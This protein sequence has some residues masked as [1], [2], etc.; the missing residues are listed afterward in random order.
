MGKS[1]NMIEVE[2]KTIF[3]LIW[4]NLFLLPLSCIFLH[5]AVSAQEKTCWNSS[6][7]TLFFDYICTGQPDCETNY[8]HPEDVVYGV[9]PSKVSCLID[10]LA[11]YESG[12]TIDE[13]YLIKD[14]PNSVFK[15]SDKAIERIKND[16]DSCFREAALVALSEKNVITYEFKNI[17]HIKKFRGKKSVSLK[18]LGDFWLY[19]YKGKNTI[20]T[21]VR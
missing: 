7:D 8:G 1:W 6:M 20:S 12:L 9:E 2:K 13:L 10:S 3:M 5:C 17:C 19:E 16:K 21:R 14:I 11:K 18:D 15:I 4:R